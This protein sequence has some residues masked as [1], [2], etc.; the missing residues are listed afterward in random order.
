[1]TVSQACIDTEVGRTVYELFEQPRTT[2]VRALLLAHQKAGRIA[3]EADIE[4][5]ASMMSGIGFSAGV[6][7]Q[8]AVR[9]DRAAVRRHV[10]AAPAIIARGLASPRPAS[11]DESVPQAD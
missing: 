3:A 10:K 1:V 8:V 11:T 4:A 2:L 6:V 7:M 9:A 5:A